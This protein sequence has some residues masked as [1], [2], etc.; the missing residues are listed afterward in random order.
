MGAFGAVF[1]SVL[2][3]F[4]VETD[5]AVKVL[6][7]APSAARTHSLAPFQTKA[8][9][10]FLREC[11]RLF[12]LRRHPNVVRVLGVIPDI[13]RAIVM[14]YISSADGVTSLH[15]W[16][17]GI[18]RA[19]G[20][21][22][23]SRF[24]ERLKIAVDICEG[25]SFI[26]SKG[27]IHCDIK[28][29]NILVASTEGKVSAKISDFGSAVAAD[30]RNEDY[31]SIGRHGGTI[32]YIAPE[33]LALGYKRVDSDDDSLRQHYLCQKSDV[34]S[35]GVVL[36]QLFRCSVSPP[37]CRKVAE[38]SERLYTASSVEAQDEVVSGSKSSAHL[39]DDWES[40][41]PSVSRY[42]TGVARESLEERGG[43]QHSG[44][45]A[46]FVEEWSDC[47]VR[48]GEKLV[49]HFRDTAGTSFASDIERKVRLCC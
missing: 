47:V 36:L 34:W 13:P 2:T 25:L 38:I 21:E 27:F 1:K 18:P 9:L 26:H 15:E 30:R 31:V 5:V 29:D 46:S 33:Q 16:I 28:L 4:G 14:E 32:G 39:D 19:S 43:A 41:V 35:L 37:C 48:I 49:H 40:E 20:L 11:A 44:M 22:E 7:S 17:E 10:G 8:S 23:K 45:E 6:M 12:A 3:R 24:L 42:R